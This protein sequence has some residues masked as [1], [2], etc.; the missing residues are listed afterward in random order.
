MWA[1]SLNHPNTRLGEEV[2][3]RRKENLTTITCVIPFPAIGYSAG[4]FL[5]ETSTCELN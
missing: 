3:K 5:H 1:V 4:D 2:A